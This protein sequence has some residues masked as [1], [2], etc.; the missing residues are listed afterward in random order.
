MKIINDLLNIAKD[1]NNRENL[2]WNEKQAAVRHQNAV[3]IALSLRDAMF[4]IL[5]A[6]RYHPQLAAI[7]N[8]LNIRLRAYNYENGGIV[9]IFELLKITQRKIF[10]YELEGFARRLNGDISIE[11]AP[12]LANPDFFPSSLLRHQPRA[13]S[14]IDKIDCIEIS[15]FLH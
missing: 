2:K 6:G 4:P 12:I 8:P 9:I 1:W 5:A 14:I 3:N 7:H 15:F 10:P 11:E 13:I